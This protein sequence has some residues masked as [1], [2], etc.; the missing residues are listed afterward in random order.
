MGRPSPLGRALAHRTRT[1][2]RV[3]D[4][5]VIQVGAVGASS[6]FELV[7]GSGDFTV[8]LPTLVLVSRFQLEE[9]YR[10]FVHFL[11]TASSSRLKTMVGGTLV[12]ASVFRFGLGVSGATIVSGSCAHPSQSWMS[13]LLTSSLSLGISSLFCSAT[14]CM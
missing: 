5:C 10:V 14:Q 8:V 9:R 11:S 12:K 3:V 2:L 4:G 13:C 1:S 6:I 7:R